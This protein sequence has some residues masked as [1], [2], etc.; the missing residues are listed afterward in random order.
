MCALA[1]L[2][3]LIAF[4]LAFVYVVDQLKRRTDVNR[5]VE[6]MSRMIEDFRTD[7]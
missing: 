4:A 6:D 7:T 3:W 5:F 1:I 2:L